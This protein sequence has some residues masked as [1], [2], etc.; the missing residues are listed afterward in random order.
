M[1]AAIHPTLAEQSLAVLA[2]DRPAQYAQ[3]RERAATMPRVSAALE[4][5]KPM[6]DEHPDFVAAAIEALSEPIL[7]AM[8]ALARIVQ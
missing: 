3:M 5:A 8:P 1:S 7:H 6:W 4:A 2:A